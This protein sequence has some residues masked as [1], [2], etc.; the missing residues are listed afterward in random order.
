MNVN[1]G[2]E[3]TLC[4]RADIDALPLHEET[5]VSFASENPYAMPS[6]ISHAT[7]IMC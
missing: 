1:T 5:G 6:G 7:T 2:M 3:K 4:M